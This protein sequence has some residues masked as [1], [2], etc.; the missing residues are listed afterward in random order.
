MKTIAE[1][2]ESSE[3]LTLLREFG[4]DFAQGYVIGRPTQY[5]EG[6][7]A[8]A[9]LDRRAADAQSKAQSSRT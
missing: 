8:D 1:F 4:V 3:V 9:P 6:D 5:L 7:Q 2:V